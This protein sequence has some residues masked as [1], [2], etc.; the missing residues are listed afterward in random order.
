MDKKFAQSGHPD[1]QYC[2]QSRSNWHGERNEAS[3]VIEMACLDVV[4]AD[5]RALHT[6]RPISP[7]IKT[8]FL[9]HDLYKVTPSLTFIDHRS[10]YVHAG[11][12]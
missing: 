10:K 12:Q 8:Q 3:F 9:L 5:E 11:T 2:S 6:Q 4:R 1:Y 7:A